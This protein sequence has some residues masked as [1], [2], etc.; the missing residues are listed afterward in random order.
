[1]IKHVATGVAAAALCALGASTALADT[2]TH[3]TAR[4][5]APLPAPPAVA[6]A[7]GLAT[8]SALTLHAGENRLDTHRVTASSWLDK[9][10]PGEM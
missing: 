8:D 6:S 7:H 10:R 1:M 4:P 9:P 3:H 2:G 5:A